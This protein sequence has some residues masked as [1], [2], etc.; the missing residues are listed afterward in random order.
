MKS[1]TIFA[2]ITFALLS[3]GLYTAL[4]LERQLAKEPNVEITLVNRD[5][6]FD[7]NERWLKSDWASRRQHLWLDRRGSGGQSARHPC[8]QAGADD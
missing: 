6:F 2:L 8:G 1:F 4:E 7:N 5:N 3:Y